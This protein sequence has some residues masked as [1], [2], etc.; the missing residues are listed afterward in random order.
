MRNQP[1]TT[2]GGIGFGGMLTILF[3]GLK[4]THNIGWDWLWV[5]SP[6]WIPLVVW[7]VIVGLMLVAMLIGTIFG[8]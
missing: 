7:G 2:R 6:M 1:N 4:L 5:L 8:R 3:I